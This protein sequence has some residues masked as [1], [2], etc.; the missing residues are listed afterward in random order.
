M[1][2]T[3][4]H[5]TS[6]TGGPQALRMSLRPP[7]TVFIQNN[8]ANNDA[9]FAHTRTELQQPRPTKDF[10]SSPAGTAIAGFKVPKASSIQ[11]FNWEGDLWGVSGGNPPT[12][13]CDV[14]VSVTE[15]H[16]Y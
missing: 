10:N 6:V 4:F 13:A 12:D 1:Q 3:L 7:N 11:L 14:D 8:D 9:Y 5:P 16:K 2:R 15:A